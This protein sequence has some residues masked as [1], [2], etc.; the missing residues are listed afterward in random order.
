MIFIKTI[1]ARDLGRQGSEMKNKKSKL[2]S[3]RLTVIIIARNE[4]EKISKCLQ[5][6]NWADEIVLVDSGSKDKTVEIAKGHK[7]LVEE[8]SGGNF[9]SWRNIGARKASHPWLLYIDADETVTESLQEEIKRAV[10]SG[11]KSAYAIPRKNIILGREMKHGGWWPDYVVRLIKKDKLNKWRGKLHEQPEIKGKVGYL[12]NH[13]IH[14][15]HDNLFDMLKKTNE[16]S[17]VEAQLLFEANHPKMVWWRFFRIMMTE[18]WLRLVKLRGYKDG[19][20]GVIYSI[21]QMWSRF[22]TYAKLWEM[23]LQTRNLRSK[24]KN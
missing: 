10:A 17:E 22:I 8:I 1:L 18:I 7:A 9:S 4:E 3:H 23:Q 12:K 20:E 13:L 14:E 24:M 16:W 2:E 19:A 6:V 21:Y 5:S 11:E 15:K